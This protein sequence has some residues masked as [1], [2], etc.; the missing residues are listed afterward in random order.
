MGA[1]YGQSNRC[2]VL[3]SW[4]L[5]ARA[6]ALS[7]D[8]IR[9]AAGG[10]VMCHARR[11]VERQWAMSVPGGPDGHRFVKAGDLP[12]AGRDPALDAA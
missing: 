7:G 2:A 12:T 5:A 4:P 3:E 10:Q 11:D 8:R 1:A 6:D 9:I